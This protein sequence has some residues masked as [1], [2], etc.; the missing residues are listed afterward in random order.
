MFRFA[1][2]LSAYGMGLADVVAE[3]QHAAAEVLSDKE[4]EGRLATSLVDLAKEVKERLAEQGF[5]PG[6]LKAE[7]FLNLRY[8][9]YGKSNS[10]MTHSDLSQL[11]RHGHSH[12]DPCCAKGRR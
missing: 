6:A 12:H 11:P 2:I 3:K 8:A 1:G 9:I 4:A 7:L 10:S 5:K